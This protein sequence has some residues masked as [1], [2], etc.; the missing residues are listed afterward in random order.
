MDIAHYDN[1]NDVSSAETGGG[2]SGKRILI[3][4]DNRLNMKLFRDLLRVKGH[5]MFEAGDG[6]EAI[7]MVRSLKP[8]LV[9]LDIQLPTISGLDVA[10]AIR[11]D[12]SLAHI[13]IIAVTAFAQSGDEEMT[14]ES[15]C[16]AYL[17]KPISITSFI[18]TVERYL[19]ADTII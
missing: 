14:K 12:A 11:A 16:D 1:S 3:V 18:E 17:T 2:G 19:Q 6:G 8:D 13:P 4:E 10:K 7:V 15:G 5:E 9:L